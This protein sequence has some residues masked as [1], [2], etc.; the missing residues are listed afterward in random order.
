MRIVGR[1]GEDGQRRGQGGQS[2]CIRSGKSLR[3]VIVAL[4]AHS[5][6]FVLLILLLG[7][8]SAN[9]L[10]SNEQHSLA[11][12]SRQSNTHTAHRVREDT[13]ALMYMFLRFTQTQS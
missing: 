6:V 7:A 8:D 12:G 11:G 2:C 1:C 4:M 13:C 3:R 9:K 10:K 5:A